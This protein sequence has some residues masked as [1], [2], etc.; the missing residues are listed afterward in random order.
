[1]TCGIP[2][3]HVHDGQAL[4]VHKLLALGVL[5]GIEAGNRRLVIDHLARQLKLP[6]QV[7]SSKVELLAFSTFHEQIF[8]TFFSR[9]YS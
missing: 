7:D 4:D 1:M 3:Q 9:Q 8:Q 5:F 6:R 2:F